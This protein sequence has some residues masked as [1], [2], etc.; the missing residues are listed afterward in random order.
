M[1]LVEVVPPASQDQGLRYDTGRNTTT[2]G[3]V[4][5]IR[6]EL[7][8]AAGLLEIHYEVARV[9]VRTA[10]QSGKTRTSSLIL[11][12]GPGAI[13]EPRFTV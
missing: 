2:V 12:A 13:P 3:E 5:A 4:E 10:G 6:K 1:A 8:E 7:V 11:D 9:K